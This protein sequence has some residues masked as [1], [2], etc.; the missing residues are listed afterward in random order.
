MADLQ[1]PYH[2]RDALEFLKEVKKQFK[3]TLVINIGDL[4]DF[5]GLNFHGVNPN[6]PSAKEELVQL[7]AFIKCLSKVFPSMLIVDSNHGALPRRK[8]RSI[9]IPDEMILNSREILQAPKTWKWFN[10]IV[11]TLPNGIRCKF[12]H[13]FS[14]N[15]IADVFKQGMSLVCGHLHTKSFVQWSQNDFGHNFAVQTGCLID[16]DSPAFD[17]DKS[18]ALRPVLSTTVIKN[19]I[20]INIP[21]MLDK[22]KRWVGYI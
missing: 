15:L 4:E 18:N 9:G 21:M 6:L 10:Q 13:N 12:K 11:M 2:H 3:P 22:K 5:H 8:A 14:G 16:C 1:A 20:P 17:Y 19:G 7:R